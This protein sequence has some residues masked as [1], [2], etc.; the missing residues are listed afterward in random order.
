[1]VHDSKF[2]RLIHLSES[3]PEV[4]RNRILEVFANHFGEVEGHTTT[5]QT[6]ADYFFSMNPDL[7]LVLTDKH[8]RSLFFDFDRNHIDYNRKGHRGKQEIIAKALGASKGVKSVLDLTAG[9]GQDAVFLAQIGF[10]VTAIERS[11]LIFLLL[12]DAK[13]RSSREDLQRLTFINADGKDFLLSSDKVLASIDAIYFDPM[14]PHKKKSALPRQEMV[15]FRDLVGDD[16][17]AAEV[18]TLA[19]SKLSGELAANRLVVKRP[20]QAEPLLA[21]PIHRFEGKTVRYDLYSR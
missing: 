18:A 3:L 15:I 10:Q 16:Q 1:M 21:N 8:K 12:E 17:D 7:A 14:Y 13:K 19:L 11:P 6:S 4:I 5:D 9:L 2:A 20:L